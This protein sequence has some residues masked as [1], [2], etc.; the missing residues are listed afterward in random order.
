MSRNIRRLAA[1]LGD[2]PNRPVARLGTI[3]TVTA[4]AA[5]DGNAAVTVTVR[6]STIDAPYLASYSPVV[7]DLVMVLLVDNAPLILGG[8]IGLP[9]F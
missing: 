8:V 1:T 6:G 3:A 5:A 4:G 2:G 9:D 7:D